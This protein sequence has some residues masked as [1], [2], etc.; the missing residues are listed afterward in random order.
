M[1]GR[2]C[3]PREEALDAGVLTPPGLLCS[4]SVHHALKIMGLQTAHMADTV[5]GQCLHPHCVASQVCEC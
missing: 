2:C 5:P 1:R 3:S 4:G